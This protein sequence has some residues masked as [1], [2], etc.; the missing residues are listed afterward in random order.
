MKKL[1]NL[2][3]ITA[4]KGILLIKENQ[5]WILPGVELE[6]GESD[7]R[8][9]YRGLKEQLYVPK[10]NITIYY[11]HDS[12]VDKTLYS[13]LDLEAKVYFGNLMGSLDPN[14]KISKA[15]FVKDFSD[16][17]LSKITSKIVSSLVGRGYFK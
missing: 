10:E 14:N 9:L 1:I 15:E 3:Y 7:S 8:C 12:F 16:Y 13:N 11:L 5:E 6:D 4:S 2:A 17:P